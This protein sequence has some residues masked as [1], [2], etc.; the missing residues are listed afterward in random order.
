MNLEVSNL[1]KFLSFITVSIF[2][3]ITLFVFLAVFYTCKHYNQ[4]LEFLRCSISMKPENVQISAR[5]R[6]ILMNLGEFDD[7]PMLLEI[8]R[9]LTL[10]SEDPPPEYME[11]VDLPPPKYENIV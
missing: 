6:Q 9:V 8:P 11:A 10:S 7:F 4:T 5:R 3:L 2:F 1:P